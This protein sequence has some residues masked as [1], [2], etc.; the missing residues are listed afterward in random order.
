MNTESNCDCVP[1]CE[2]KS[3]RSSLYVFTAK[4]NLLSNFFNLI[5][6]YLFTFQMNT[7]SNCDCVPTCE[8]KSSRSSLYVFTAKKKTSFEFLQLYSTLYLMFLLFKLNCSH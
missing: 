4:K 8:Y 2:Y 3:S 7:E 5:Q 6:Q 1:T